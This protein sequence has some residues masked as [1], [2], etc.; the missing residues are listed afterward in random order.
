MNTSS[1]STGFD[2]Q[3]ESIQ[4]HTCTGHGM[5]AAHRWHFACALALLITFGHT[6]L[7]ATFAW[8]DSFCQRH[9]SQ[10]NSTEHNQTK[11]YVQD[12]AL[13][14][15]RKVSSTCS[16]VG[17]VDLVLKYLQVAFASFQL[18]LHAHS[19][20]SCVR[21]SAFAH[22]VSKCV[23]KFGPVRTT[24]PVAKMYFADKLSWTLNPV[25]MC[26]LTSWK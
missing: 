20:F 15:A 14:Q 18:P 25:G 19:C 12:S 17:T 23:P 16:G 10:D 11:H 8:F 6:F 1:P 5:L 22:C 21:G 3:Q 13:A 26:L 4:K 24:T 9:G 7:K 2:A